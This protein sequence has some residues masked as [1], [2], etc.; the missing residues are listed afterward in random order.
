L[1]GELVQF[2]DL[3]RSFFFGWTFP[4]GGGLTGIR[5]HEQLQRAALQM[6]WTRPA[7]CIFFYPFT[8]GCKPTNSCFQ[9]RFSNRPPGV[10]LPGNFCAEKNRRRSAG[11]QSPFLISIN[12]RE[13]RAAGA[14]FYPGD[15]SVHAHSPTWQRFFFP[16]ALFWIEPMKEQYVIAGTSLAPPSKPAPPRANDEAPHL[17][18]AP[19]GHDSCVPDYFYGDGI[20][21]I[22]SAPWRLRKRNS[23]FAPVPLTDAIVLFGGHGPSQGNVRPNRQPARTL[24]NPPPPLPRL[25]SL[26]LRTQRNWLRSLPPSVAHSGK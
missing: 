4:F 25:S 11:I 1:Q 16:T 18:V 23:A 15:R 12:N 24:P 17:F 22:H 8:S 5:I 14:K 2:Q 21:P 6:V 13:W 10:N 26:I 19:P 20:I 7:A 3:D 9:P